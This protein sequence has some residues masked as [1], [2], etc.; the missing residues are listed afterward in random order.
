MAGPLEITGENV[1]REMRKEIDRQGKRSVRTTIV[2]EVRFLAHAAAP[3]GW[4][5]ADG[6]AL[7]RDVF[8]ALFAVLGTRFGA[9]SA[10]AF[11][12]PTVAAPSG[13]IAVI[14]F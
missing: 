4:L 2:G 7:Q 6:R 11:N 13:L 5:I 9:P 3:N 8:P 1:L 10:A 12:I 14:K